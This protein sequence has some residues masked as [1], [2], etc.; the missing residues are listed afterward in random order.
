MPGSM[1]NISM[2]SIGQSPAD[3]A[4]EM[5]KEYHL[6]LQNQISLLGEK[7]QETIQQT[8][9]GHI[10]RDGSTGKLAEAM[11]SNFWT[12]A[13][14]CGFWIGDLDYLDAEVKYWYWQNYGYAISGR[15]IPPP[16]RGYFPGQNPPMGGTD[17]E[18][19]THTG[20]RKDYLMIPKKPLEAMNYLET[21]I[22]QLEIDIPVMLA[23][24]EKA[25]E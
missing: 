5:D 16:S 8:I 17:G 20:D 19:W 24:I 23:T 10:K 13:N 14:S 2:K 9:R 21:G 4:R 11:K 6:E 1:I 22:Y 7:I 3:F 12:A 15:S 18:K 25:I